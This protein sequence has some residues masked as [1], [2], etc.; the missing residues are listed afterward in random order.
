MEVKGFTIVNSETLFIF[1]MSTTTHQEKTFYVLCEDRHEMLNWVLTFA[2][3][4]SLSVNQTLFNTK[5]KVCG[6]TCLLMKA[7]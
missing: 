5:D 4:Q 6:V 2:G 7:G 1:G 3:L